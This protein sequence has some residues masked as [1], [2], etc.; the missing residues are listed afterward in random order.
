MSTM[1]PSGCIDEFLDC[2]L[3]GEARQ[4]TKMALE[5][6]DWGVPEDLIITDLLASAQRQVGERWHR[7]ELSVAEE[8]LATG[9]AESA[10]HALADATAA[11]STG[12]TVVVACAEGDWHSV[13][14]HMFA[15]QLRARGAAVVFLGASTPAEH[16]ATFLQRHRPDVLA[17][18]CHIPLYYTGVTRL[19]DAA[20]AVGIPVIAGGRAF[21]DCPER[22][23]RLGADGW[24]GDVAEA[25][26][27]MAGWRDERPTV[28]PEPTP[29]NAGAVELDARARELAATAWGDLA[30]RFP[31]M[32]RYDQ[33]QLA[34]TRED[35]AF[36]VQFVAA[37]QLVGD[38][39][40]LT[41]FLDWLALLLER[42]GVPERALHAG[43]EALH[44]LLRDVSQAAGDLGDIG[45]RHLAERVCC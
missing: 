33:R 10:L 2:A 1:A 30:C 25:A 14:A 42:R 38:Q 6:L 44:P 19:V 7:N 23:G 31:A 16:V 11:P 4:A 26:A 32:A 40:V 12:A 20:H 28:R 43:L 27:V 17:V 39:E 34:R 9:A 24:A 22:A 36:I 15:E 8:H 35:L 37:A 5:L 29:V 21:H 18:S 3:V 13:P 45:I 41:T